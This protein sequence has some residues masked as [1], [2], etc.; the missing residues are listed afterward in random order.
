MAVGVPA[1]PGMLPTPPSQAATPGPRS[2][3]PAK[4]GD[5]HSSLARWQGLML[6][7]GAMGLPSSSVA[8]EICPGTCRAPGGDTAWGHPSH[9]G[10][11]LAPPAASSPRWWQSCERRGGG[12]SHRVPV[13]HTAPSDPPAGSWCLQQGA[14][15]APRSIPRDQLW[16]PGC[17]PPPRHTYP[18]PRECPQSR[19][20]LFPLRAL[21]QA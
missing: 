18:V 5:G 14:A 4:D 13:G 21:A 17:P 16:A 10:P 15:P 11:Y 7:R 6:E 19:T 12:G 20:L 9:A 3:R 8:P 2:P 1:P